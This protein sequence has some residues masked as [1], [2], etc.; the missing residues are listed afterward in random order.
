ML[1]ALD[2]YKRDG[3]ER[4]GKG[5]NSDGACK[6]AWR[7][8][9]LTS[10]PASGSPQSF[11]HLNLISIRFFPTSPLSYNDSV[12]H[13][14]YHIFT[15]F[16]IGDGE[17]LDRITVYLTTVAASYM[18]HADCSKRKSAPLAASAKEPPTFNFQ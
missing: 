13:S 4:E 6:D 3:K 16:A 10:L 1:P 17:L 7:Q 15:S 12:V 14:L 8:K 2:I 9:F 11:S 5:M 18:R